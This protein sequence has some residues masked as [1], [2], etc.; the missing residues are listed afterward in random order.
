MK[1]LQVSYSWA[2]PT[3]SKFTTTT[4]EFFIIDENVFVFKTD[5][6]THGFV[7]FT[8]LAL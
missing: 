4:P 6:A 5:F 7:I 8:A 2:N 3:T 1:G